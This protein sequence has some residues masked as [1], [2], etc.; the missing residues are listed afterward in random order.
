MGSQVRVNAGWYKDRLNEAFGYEA[1]A[2]AEVDEVPNQVPLIVKSV[3][4]VAL[5]LLK[6]FRNVAYAGVKGRI[7]PSVMMSCFA[8]HA[9]QPGLSLSDMVIRQA[10]LTAASIRQAAARREK[11]IVVNPVFPRDCF[12]DRWPENLSQ[13]E[14]FASK[15]TE[16]ADGLAYYKRHGASL[17]DLQEWLRER[18]GGYVVSSSI[19]RF[20]R[21]NGSAVQY[22]AQ[23]YTPRGGLY[24]PSAPAL[25]GIGAAGTVTGVAASPHT[26]R[27]GLLP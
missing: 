12:T 10:C 16:L 9:A 25:V 21:R 2:D 7:P 23:G 20:N 24:V 8:G 13:Q 15:L 11:V 5:Q 19:R 22:G 1:R 26:F 18:F 27:G 17:E 4:T 6:R 3:T 14:E